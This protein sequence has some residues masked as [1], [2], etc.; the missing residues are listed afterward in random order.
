MPIDLH[1]QLLFLR[2]LQKLDLELH[3][4]REKISFLPSSLRETETHYHGL[5]QEMQKLSTELSTTERTKKGDE[6]ELESS[7]VKLREREARLYAIKTQR[8][9]QAALQEIAAGKKLNRERED[10]ILAAMEKIEK[11]TEKIKQLEPTLSDKEKQYLAL[12]EEMKQKEQEFT[13]DLNDLEQKRPDILANIDKVVL[14]KYELVQKR[15][16]DPISSVMRGI[17]SG[18][19]MNIPPQLLNEILRYKELKQC[20]TCHRLLTVDEG[21]DVDHVHSPN[22]AERNSG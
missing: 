22:N 12:C 6:L 11:L 14:R 9:Y 18:C 1:G 19:H 15:H 13:K 8:E 20:P 3:H 17:C 21:K 2:E 10:F 4:V 5:Q 16:P 7:V